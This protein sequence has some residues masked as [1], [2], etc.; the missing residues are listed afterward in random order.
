M[1]AANNTEE[2]PWT[3]DWQTPFA[4][5]DAGQLNPTGEEEM[6]ALGSRFRDL[7][8]TLLGRPYSPSAYQF[9]STQ[10]K[11]FHVAVAAI[12]VSSLLGS[13]W[14]LI[15]PSSNKYAQATSMW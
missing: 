11:L 14:R 3:R 4:K 13:Q 5:Q 10:V 15:R 6:Q 1:Q 8:P 12:A 7:F 9:I 2:H